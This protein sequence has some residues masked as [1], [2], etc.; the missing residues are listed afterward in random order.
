MNSQV[1]KYAFK[2]FIILLVVTIIFSIFSLQLAKEKKDFIYVVPKIK[3]FEVLNTNIG[4]YSLESLDNNNSNQKIEKVNFLNGSIF[5]NVPNGNYKVKG[6]YLEGSDE[7]FLEKKKDWEKVY[8]DLEG[9]NFT[10][11]GKI[12]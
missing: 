10:N 8:L 9:V 4:D 5:Y 1:S 7:K 12:S 2:N 6:S 11:L 3:N